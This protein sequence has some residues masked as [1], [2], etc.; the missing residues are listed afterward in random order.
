MPVLRDW[1]FALMMIFAVTVVGAVG[2]V[3]TGICVMMGRIVGSGIDIFPNMHIAAHGLDIDDTAAVA[4]DMTV[5][6]FNS[7]RPEERVD[8][9]LLISYP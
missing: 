9:V 5:A 2:I 3:G 1:H 4:A 8:M 6:S 7:N